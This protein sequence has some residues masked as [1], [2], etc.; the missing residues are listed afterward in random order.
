[1][2]VIDMSQ[3]DR[4]KCKVRQRT[5]KHVETRTEII[6]IIHQGNLFEIIVV[7]P[8]GDVP[9]LPKSN[10]EVWSKLLWKYTIVF[11]GNFSKGKHKPFQHLVI[12]LLFI[13]QVPNLNYSLLSVANWQHQEFRSIP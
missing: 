6:Y 5:Y 2:L 9:V 3:S 4:G 8:E 13:R 11:A 12:I 7:L 1:M 10:T